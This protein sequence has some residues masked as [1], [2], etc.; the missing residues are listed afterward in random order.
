MQFLIKALAPI[1][2]ALGPK[3][4][5]LV[6]GVLPLATALGNWVISGQFNA[7]SIVSAAL[8]AVVAAGVYF[9]PNK[10]TAQPVVVAAPAPSSQATPP[11]RV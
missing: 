7:T 5:A 11:P 2:G 9:V 10:S 6:A 1:A 3:A 4:K 8:G